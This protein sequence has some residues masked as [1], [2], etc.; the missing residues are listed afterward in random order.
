MH[1]IQKFL[2]GSQVAR[3][4]VDGLSGF[5]ERNHS[6]VGCDHRDRIREQTVEP[7]LVGEYALNSGATEFWLCADYSK[8]PRS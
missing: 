5:G 4:V 8:A 3:C 7:V 6:S 2:I 1:V